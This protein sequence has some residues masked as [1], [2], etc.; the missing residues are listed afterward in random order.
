MNMDVA[1]LEERLSENELFEI[2]RAKRDEDTVL[3][4]LKEIAHRKSLRRMEIFQAVLED[5]VQ[6]AAAKRI[7]ALEL[8]TEHLPENRKLLISHLTSKEPSVFAGVVQALG[9]IGD[10]ESLVQLEK[11]TAPNDGA[12]AKTLA[13]AKVLLSYRLRINRNL[14]AAPPEE[15]L[16][17]V[18][19]GSAVAT[20]KAKPETVREAIRDVQRRLPAI[21]LAEQGALQLLCRSA[22]L[23]LL[24]TEEFVSSN[25]LQT[26]FNRNAL[27]LVLLR[28]GL[29]LERYSLSQYLFTQP[30]QDRKKAIVL[31]TRPSGEL[32]YAGKIQLSKNGAAFVVKSVESR[33]ASKIEVQGQYHAGRRAFKFSKIIAG[34]TVAAIDKPAD[35]P[36]RVTRSVR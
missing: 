11:M 24:F 8:G 35:T 33:Y 21:Q 19:G 1:K 16:L 9:Q 6:V 25:A 22:E 13:F 12:A 4:A 36:R 20:K 2:V 3:S 10:E 5:S 31:A 32:S 30:S 15:D 7:A 27:P 18:E 23:L 14:L 28:K 34:T 29:S 26:I 17:E